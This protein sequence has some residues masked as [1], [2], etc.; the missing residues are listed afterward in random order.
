MPAARSS[1][2][3]AA[4]TDP[5]HARPLGVGECPGLL[6]RL[7]MIP[8][9]RDRRGRRHTL[10]SVLAVSAAAVLAGPAPWP[11]SP[12]GPPTRPGRSYRA[13]PN[14]V[15]S[16]SMVDPLRHND[17]IYSVVVTPFDEAL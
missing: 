6:E 9:P 16:R 17:F 1:P 10:A 4:V 2:I 7:A 5:D 13:S 12:S 3:P 8:D 15:T 14:E 11:R